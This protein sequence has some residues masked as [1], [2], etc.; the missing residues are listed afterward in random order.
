MLA[1][2]YQ[3]ER[4]RARGYTNSDHTNDTDTTADT[5]DTTGDSTGLDDALCMVSCVPG[6]E[7]ESEEERGISTLNGP[8]HLGYCIDEVAG[9]SDSAG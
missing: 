2:L 5:L 3:P 4:G 9:D 8:T 7:E 1:L 6:N